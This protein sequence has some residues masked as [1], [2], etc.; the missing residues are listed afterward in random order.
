MKMISTPSKSLYQPSQTSLNKTKIRT[1]C[2][3]VYRCCLY[4]SKL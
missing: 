1:T 4:F 2:L 3:S